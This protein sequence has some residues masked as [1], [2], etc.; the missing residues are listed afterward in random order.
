ML[1]FYSALQVSKSLM[2]SGAVILV[3][4]HLQ[5]RE[6]LISCRIC[7]RSWSAIF[8]YFCGS[9]DVCCTMKGILF[10]H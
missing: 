10:S 4:A 8:L 1:V 6:R 7:L 3:W 9:N 5:G 2:L